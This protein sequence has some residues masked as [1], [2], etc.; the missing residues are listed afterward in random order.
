MKLTGRDEFQIP[1][2]VLNRIDRYTVAAPLRSGQVAE[3]VRRLSQKHMDA[4]ASDL[5]VAIALDPRIAT[6][7]G[8][9]YFSIMDGARPVERGVAKFFNAVKERLQA[10]A[11]RSLRGAGRW[12]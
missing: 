4:I 9:H 10:G 3:I 5:E 7:L 11:I 6:R 2:P 8:E 1:T 12:P